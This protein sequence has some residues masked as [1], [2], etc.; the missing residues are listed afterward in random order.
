MRRFPQSVRSEGGHMI[1]WLA[2]AWLVLAF[3]VPAR[4]QSAGISGT[5][6]DESGAGVPGATVQLTGGARR[7]STTTGQGGAYRFSGLVSG[8]YQ[9]TVSL[10][11]FSTA[12]RNDIAVSSMDLAVPA[13]TLTLANLNETVVVS[14]TKVESQLVDAPATMSVLT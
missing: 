13:I 10:G 4:G 11:G 1:R 3:T 9:L 6:V 14:A 7:E 5:V 2:A 12:T 8:T